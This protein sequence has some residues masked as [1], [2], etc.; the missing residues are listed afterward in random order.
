[1]LVLF[2]TKSSAMCRNLRA[3]SGAGESSRLNSVFITTL[4]LLGNSLR[5]ELILSCLERA[6]LFSS[7]VHLARMNAGFSL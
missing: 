6:R 3:R 4:G 7:A 2:S 1:M 5:A